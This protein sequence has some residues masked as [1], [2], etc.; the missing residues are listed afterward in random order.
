MQ[1]TI[2]FLLLILN[3]ILFK[4]QNISSGLYFAA[5]N[6]IKEERTSLILSPEFNA[7]KGFTLDFDIKFRSEE[8]NYGYVFRIIV[9]NEKSFDLIANI[10]PGKK[11]LNLIE[12]DNIYL[13]FDEELLKQYT[14]NKWVHIRCSIYPDSLRLVFDNQML[15]DRY[16]PINIKNVKFY[17]GYSDHNKF[18]SSDVPPMSIRN[19]KITDG[20][21]K[22]I[23]YWPLKEHQPYSCSDS[24]HHIPATVTNPTWEINKH[25]KW[26]KEKTLELPIYPQICHAPSKGNIYFANSSSVLVYSTTDD[27]LDTIF[28]AHGAPYTE[29]N[30]Q[31]IYHPYY[32]ELWSYDFDTL[33]WISIFNFKDNTWTRN[34]REIKNPEYSQHNAFVS[35]NDSCLYIFGGYGNYQYKNQILKKS[36]TQDNWKSVTYSEEIPPRYLSG[37]GYKNRDTILVFGGCGN[38][39][40]KQE[41][42]IINYYDLY[43]IDI[44]TFKTKK[45]WTIPND[46]KNFVIGNNIVADEKNNKLYALCFPNDCSNS[47]I[48]LKSF[49]LDS[50]NSC[51]NYADTIPF[52]FNDVNSFCTLYYDSLQSQLYAVTNY[53]HN[54]KSN[55]NVYS[56]AYPP[57]KV[58]DTLQTA[59]GRKAIL[60]RSF[61]FISVGVC[62]IAGIGCIYF[63]YRRRRRRKRNFNPN[64][65]VTTNT[66]RLHETTS[67]EENYKPKLTVHRKS[68]ILFLDGF[69]VWDK[70]GIDITKSFTPILKQL[71]IL[72]I[73]YSVN[74]KK[75][76]S[77]VTL[78]ELLWFDKMDESAQNNRRVNIRKLKLLLEKLDGAELVKESTY[79]SVK[80]TQ[81][82]C[83][84][85]EVCNCIDKVKNNEPITA[86]N[87]NDLPLNLLSGQ[88]LPYVQTDWLDSFK[89]N[90]ANSVLDTA[91]SLSKQEYIKGNN[92]LLI[93]IANSMFAHDKTDEYALI[94]KCQALY[95]NGRTSLA[96]TTFDTFC[97]EYKA[98]L[99]TDYTKT[100]NEVINCQ[101]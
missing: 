73:L 23:A 36:R 35:P 13:A 64:S 18:H 90:Y 54:N 31:L 60:Q 94:L 88:L 32:N 67:E 1:K 34:D 24:L 45:L 50:G 9:D 79:W 74:N 52:T 65:P 84:Y 38:P 91:I 98:M 39:Q 68:S 53:N 33:K 47:Y 46:T 22:T 28:S 57:L 96:K 17:F 83:D 10:T 25:T 99:N 16:K 92:E 87:I 26:V 100:F 86:T 48:L 2:L 4:S 80:F 59:T 12:G 62:I 101:L 77:N 27:T 55:I 93:Q 49:D 14:W 71:L 78:R 82:Y 69:Q 3:P 44:N 41:L 7:S 37:S 43:A 42:G 8:H 97:N 56:L 81:T 89:S 5:H 76:I 85:I 58:E 66:D 21:N 72:I 40:G 20:K 63:C 75:G 19:I 29:I 61:F 6:A 70:N 30:N 11:T 51:T 15:Q 95:K